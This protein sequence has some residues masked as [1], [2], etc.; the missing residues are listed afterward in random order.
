MLLN[1]KNNNK[2][3]KIINLHTGVSIS[4]NNNEN[5]VMD[6]PVDKFVYYAGFQ[7]KGFEVKTFKNCMIYEAKEDKVEQTGILDKEQVEKN[8]ERVSK[9][10]VRKTTYV[11]KNK[12]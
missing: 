2:E 1:I 3:Q 8:K 6:C 7:N 5:V 9:A 11:P 12:K 10:P 4:L